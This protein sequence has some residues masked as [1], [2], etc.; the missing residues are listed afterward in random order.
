MYTKS[1]LTFVVQGNIRPDIGVCMSSIRKYFPES[2]IIFS[3][4]AGTNIAGVDCDEAV[5]SIDPRDCGN[6]YYPDNPW[7]ASHLNNFNRQLVS[8]LNG[9]K[10]V[11]TPLAVKWRP[12][13]VLSSDAIWQKYAAYCQQKIP[14]DKKWSMFHER[15]GMLCP[16]NPHTTSLAYHTCD[17]IAIGHTN[18]LVDMYDIPLQTRAEA[19]YSFLHGLRHPKRHRTYRYACEQELWLRNLDK[20][21]ISYIKPSIYYETNE[22]IIRDSELSFFNNLFFLNYA[23]SCFSARFDNLKKTTNTWAYKEKHYLHWLKDPASIG[24]NFLS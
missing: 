12:D 22:D 7:K 10:L 9:L 13:F 6:V 11:R 5:F 14:R 20:H 23:T 17:F 3:T 24:R 18:D 21:A 2:T 19:Q 1:E 16:C 8:S 4:W 15:I